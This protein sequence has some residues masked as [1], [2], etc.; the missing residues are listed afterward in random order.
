MQQTTSN[1]CNLQERVRN[2]TK[3]QFIWTSAWLITTALLAFGP[4][5]LWDFAQTF[6][7]I[8]VILNVL[9]GIKMLLVNKAYLNGLDEMQ[10]K[11]HFNAMA[12]SLG[13]TMISGTL[14]GLL[15]PAGLIDFSPNPSN[16]L[17]V[18]G[19]SYL[20]AVVINNKAYS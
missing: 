17:F 20:V 2:N 7:W 10:R 4:K 16:L 15:K 12:I 13:I 1:N 9:M 5:L 6:T 8:A 3:S 11:I 19:I 14:Y 18:M